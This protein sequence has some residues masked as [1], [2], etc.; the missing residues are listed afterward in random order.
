MRL[1]LASMPWLAVDTP[2]L[3]VGILRRRVSEACPSIEISEF[4]GAVHWAEYLLD[5]SGGDLTPNEYAR[6]GDKGLA[7]GLGDWVFA[8]A[9]YD[10]P[11][12]R[13]AELRRHADDWQFELALAERMRLLAG[14][15]VEQAA[16]EILGRD[17]DVVGFTTTF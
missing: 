11:G 14:P 7:H 2:S 15:F 9:L 3:P 5:A 17:P 13:L 16:T 8:G 1:C 10:D 6:L 4:H 12:W